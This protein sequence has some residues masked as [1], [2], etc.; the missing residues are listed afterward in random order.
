MKSLARIALINLALVLA[1]GIAAELVFGGWVFGPDFG[2]LN[3]PRNEWR[4]F[5]TSRLMPDGSAI[6]Y[7]RDTY[8]F[9]GGIDGKPEAVDVVVL[10]GSTTNE[11]Y[12]DD[13]NTWV[14][15]LEKSFRADGV[16]L[17]FANASVDGQTSIGHVAA[18][19][20]WLTRIPGFR[21]RDAIVYIGINDMALG[22]DD[23][24]QFDRMMSPERSRR[25]RQYI[26]N[27]SALY[28]LFRTVRGSWFAR[29]AHLVHGDLRW[30]E[31]EWVPL[32]ARADI[33]ALRATLRPKLAA[34]ATRLEGLAAKI[35]QMGARPIFVTQRR[36]D[37]KIL[38]GVPYVRTN[39][40]AP[41]LGDGEAR[42]LGWFDEVT[43]D[44]CA[45]LRL[46]C[47]D[48]GSRLEFAD[49]DFY[50]GIH[51]TPSGSA[52]IA[53]FLYHELKDVLR[54]RDAAA[55]RSPGIPGLRPK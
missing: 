14:A 10:G 40:G 26:M 41:V 39:A 18:I 45:K 34:Y 8:G 13:A 5:D 29:E 4:T 19:E 21:P 12:V 54:P 44:T 23:Q 2:M 35:E 33:D 15:R 49:G 25:V 22:S 20:Q 27:K 55:S 9:R 32:E 47:V 7:S 6:V 28:N 31:A 42:T 50:D 1:A 17:T 24:H 48:L 52:R 3:L 43:L 16:H 30:F 38:E 11:R 37:Y 46:V 53:A 51:T 36:G